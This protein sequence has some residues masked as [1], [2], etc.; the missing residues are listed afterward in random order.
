MLFRA[1]RTSTG[2]PRSRSAITRFTAPSSAACNIIRWLRPCMLSPVK[3]A[4]VV[5]VLLMALL[6]VGSPPV[7]A[8]DGSPPTIRLYGDAG[9]GWGL[10]ASA[11]TT[12]GPNLT[13][14][15]GYPVILV[16]SGEAGVTHDWFID[17]ND[18]KQPDVGEPKVP[19]FIGPSPQSSPPITPDRNGTW[20]YRC[21]YH[22]NT[23]FGTIHVM[24][25]TNVTLYGNAGFGW[26]FSNTTIQKPGPSLAFLAGTNVTFTL[27]AN[28]TGITHDFFI[29]YDGSHTPTPGVEPITGDFFGGNAKNYTLPIDRAG[30]FT[31][32][33]QY[34]PAV[35][36]G[37]VL[38]YGTPPHGGGFNVAL[39]PGIM[40]IALSGVLIFAAV[41]HVRAVR[42]AK[43]SK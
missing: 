18:N 34:H 36:F 22:P 43:R 25:Q 31:Y 8:A 35:M 23:M 24:P 37:T 40:L 21:A 16:L 10:N 17:Y 15:L 42:A 11:L 5:A 13:V 12:P 30:N 14:L 26:G 20:T 32:Y 2:S 3:A 29:D 41:Y 7:S 19:D 28:D 39:I 6:M 33:C 9:R 38:I 27:I 4:A 1:I